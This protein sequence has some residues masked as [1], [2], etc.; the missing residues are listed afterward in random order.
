MLDPPIDSSGFAS[1]TTLRTSEGTGHAGSE[2][3]I[4]HLPESRATSSRYMGC[5]RSTNRALILNHL[6]EGIS[7]YRYGHDLQTFLRRGKDESRT[8]MASIPS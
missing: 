3:R 1:A 4:E 6:G 5:L 7:S 8:S 2:A